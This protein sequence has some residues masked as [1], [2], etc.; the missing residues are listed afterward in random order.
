MPRYIAFLRAVNVGGRIVKMADLAQHFRTLGHADVQTFIASGNVIFS[1]RSRSTQALAAALERGLEP[2]LGFRT[3]AFVRRDDEVQ[4][5]AARATSLQ[6]SFREGAGPQG[7]VNV[8]LLAQPLSPVQAESLA[9]L[10]SELDDFS[11][12]GAEVCWMCK[13]RQSDS[14]FSNVVFERRL[15]T[16]ATIRRASMLERLAEHLRGEAGSG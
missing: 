13:S 3:E 6:A 14:K 12:S 5:L 9:G 16:K 4:A 10:R 7:E 15:A 11:H 1:S 8:L 2:M